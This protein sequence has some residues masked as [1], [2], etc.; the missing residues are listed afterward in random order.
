MQIADEVRPLD[1]IDGIE[2]KCDANHMIIIILSAAQ[3]ARAVRDV[4]IAD[5]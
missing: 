2:M 1:R 3:R 4:A 5:L